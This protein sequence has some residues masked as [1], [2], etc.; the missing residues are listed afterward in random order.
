[1][2]LGVKRH[3]ASGH[4]I[5]R[6]Q[7]GLIMARYTRII[8]CRPC[9]NLYTAWAA[10]MVCVRVQCCYACAALGWSRCPSCLGRA[11]KRC[12]SCCGSGRLWKTDIHG[13]RHVDSCW[14]CHGTGRRRSVTHFTSPHLTRRLI[15]IHTAALLVHGQVTII[16]VVSVGLSVCLSVCLFVCLCRVFFSAVFDPISIKLRHMLYVWV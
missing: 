3:L 14:H 15:T 2:C 13:R 7:H 12:I 4:E 1:M 8:N 11:F 9:C 10:S 6:L 5:S 16:F